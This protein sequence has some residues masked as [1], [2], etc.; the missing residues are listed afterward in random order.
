MDASNQMIFDSRNMGNKWTGSSPRCPL[1][2]HSLV[3]SKNNCYFVRIGPIHDID[4]TCTFRP[5]FP[6]LQCIKDRY[7]YYMIMFN[8]HLFSNVVIMALNYILFPIL[9]QNLEKCTFLGI[10]LFSLHQHTATSNII[11]QQH[12]IYINSTQEHWKKELYRGLSYT[13]EG[14]RNSDLNFLLLLILSQC[15][16]V[17]NQC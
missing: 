2:Y 11:I 9:V 10:Y 8:K 3:Y 4:L 15:T 17:T 13:G 1:W 14:D 5:F 6:F 16:T 7:Q 12:S